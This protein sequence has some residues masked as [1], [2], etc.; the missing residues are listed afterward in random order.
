MVPA[1]A[2]YPPGRGGELSPARI[3]VPRHAPIVAACG[4]APAAVRWWP[5]RAFRFQR[6]RAVG[7]VFSSHRTPGGRAFPVKGS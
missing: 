3:R 4:A 5:N 6:S 7:P 2:R 1:P